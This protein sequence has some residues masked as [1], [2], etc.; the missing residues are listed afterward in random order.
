MNR[1]ITPGFVAVN[2][3]LMATA[4]G[5]ASASWWPIYQDPHFAIMVGITILVGSI[6]A[7]AA[8]VRRW[9]AAVVVPLT[10]VAFA[11]LGVGLAVPSESLYGVAPTL[12]G[13]RDLFGSVA[14]GWKQLLTI[15]L[16]VGT[17]QGLLV[18][19]FVAVLLTVVV[20]LTIALRARRGDIAVGAPVVLFLVGIAFGSREAAWPMQLSLGLLATVLLWLIWRRWHRR[21][22]A[23]RLLDG[24][25][26][27]RVLG[28]RTVVGALVV[29]LIAG[30]CAVAT[31]SVLPPQNERTV[32]RSTIEQPFDPRDYASPLAGFRQYLKNGRDEQ[33]ILSVSGLPAGGRIRIATLDTYDGVVYAV[34]SEEVSSESG[35]FTR[36]PQRFDQSG[37]A[38]DEVTLEVTVGDYDGVWLPTI[39]K[40]ESIDFDGRR[41]SELRDAFYYNDTSGTAAVLGGLEAG[42]EYTLTA[43][44]PTEL[45]TSRLAALSAG[46]ATVPQLG[47]VPAELGT[48]IEQYTSGADSQG[49]RLV[50]VLEGLAEEGY[51]S[52]GITEDEPPSRSGHS[53]DRITELLSGQRMI[54]DGEQYAVAAAL[55]ANELGFPA[56]VVFGFTPGEAGSDGDVEITGSM[57]SSW[58]EI[59]TAELG[60]VAVDPTPE[61]REIP[62]EQPEDPSTVSRPQSVVQPPIEE[63]EL[64]DNQSPTEAVDTDPEVTEGWVLVLLAIARVLGWTLL[65]IAVLLSPFLV[66]IAAKLRRRALRRKAASP[67]ARITGGWREFEDAV[68]DHGYIPPAAATRSEFAAT[69]GGDTSVL[70]AT[71]TDRATFAPSRPSA[72][73]AAKLWRSVDELTASLDDGLSRWG[74]LRARVSVRS[75]GGDS[76]RG[77]LARQARQSR[78]RGPKR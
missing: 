62:E 70:V 23:V 10:L 17:Y 30:A 1:A 74:R 41:A 61:E 7:V 52:H 45:G 71:A 38:G 46:S 65:V 75:L 68:I 15:T 36:V 34:G 55:M 54:G 8:A 53:S 73:E 67:L 58:I 48:R 24:A 60:W 56:R 9:P 66:I 29:L 14:L 25:A 32:L 12:E 27:Q 57:V 22:V 40:F 37:V 59:N 42:D 21:R 44:V 69:V 76:V 33:V 31:T 63:Q 64:T 20:G 4:V 35:A 11:A 50:A 39:G 5:I 13:L 78:S 49:E 72:D 51:I 19:A 2:T 47:A 18:P 43:V 77:L 6:I 16:P 3:L 26:R 28:I